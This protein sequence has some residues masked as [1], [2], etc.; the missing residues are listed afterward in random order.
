M[1][2]FQIYKEVE[3]K[4]TSN[5][6]GAQLEIYVLRPETDLIGKLVERLPMLLLLFFNQHLFP[7]DHGT[8]FKPFIN[9]QNQQI[10]QYFSETQKMK[11]WLRLKM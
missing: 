2:N 9:C 8:A 3:Y 4:K 7:A 11:I 6:Y 5:I 1:K 10:E